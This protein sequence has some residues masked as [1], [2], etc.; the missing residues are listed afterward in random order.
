MA[1]AV[2]VLVAAAVAG[3]SA[4]TGDSGTG[5]ERPDRSREGPQGPGASGTDT[6]TRGPRPRG[7]STSARS[8]AEEGDI[9]IEIRVGGERFTA[10]VNDTPAS[11]DLVAQLPQTVRMRD[12]GGVEKTGPLVS[13]LRLDGQATG[14]DPAIGDLGYY[15]PGNDLVLYYGDQSYFD[16]IVVLGT[17]DPDATSRLAQ[18]PGNITVQVTAPAS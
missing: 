9:D 7:P 12:H 3:C 13:P 16:G 2:T 18:M 1:R 6:T 17:L 5:A 8:T 15:A 14:A 4:T 11:R 10:T